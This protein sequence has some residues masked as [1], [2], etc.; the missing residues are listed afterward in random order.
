ME[1]E[2]ASDNFLS[3]FQKEGV[4]Q[5]CGN[6][7]EDYDEVVDFS[8][9]KGAQALPGSGERPSCQECGEQDQENGGG[10]YGV[11]DH[12]GLFYCGRCWKAWDGEDKDNIMKPAWQQRKAYKEK[13]RMEN[14][15]GN[16][17]DQYDAEAEEGT[18]DIEGAWSP[19]EKGV[20]ESGDQALPGSWER[21]LCVECGNDEG[22]EGG[23]RYGHGPD[24]EKFFC[25]R[26]WKSWDG[27]A[28]RR[29]MMAYAPANR[30]DFEDR[31]A[32]DPMLHV[33]PPND[34]M[35]LEDPAFYDMDMD[36]ASMTRQGEAEDQDVDG[37]DQEDEGDAAE[38]EFRFDGDDGPFSFEQFLEYYE[39]Q[40]EALRRW[41]AGAPAGAGADGGRGPSEMELTASSFKDAHAP[42][43]DDEEVVD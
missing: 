36:P 39:D 15:E 40:E 33:P 20:N 38:E 29:M 23:G 21:P 22:E 12:E 32:M 3:R 5:E 10:R 24:N 13:E 35:K 42:P 43:M 41:E 4:D 6:A 8:Q 28:Q 37:D 26:C 34:P 14:D 16:F 9:G 19:D 27:E 17:F 11:D 30:L 7:E 18:D 25:G 2:E 31:H 1:T